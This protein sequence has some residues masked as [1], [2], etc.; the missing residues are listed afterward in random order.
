V[1]ARV[2]NQVSLELSDINVESTVETKRSRQG[3]DGLS[4]QSVEVGVGRTLN[5]EITAADVVDGLVV[6][7]DSHIGVLEKRVSGKHGVVGFNHGGGNLWGRVDGESE[8]RLAAVVNRQTLK[9]KRAETRS[10]TST[11]SVED[12]ETLKTSAVVSK[13]ADAV[14]NKVDNFLSDGV[15]TTGVVVSS[16]LLSGNQLF[17]VVQLT[18]GSGADFVNDGWFKV[19]EDSARDVLTSTSLG[20]EGVESVV[21][22]TDGLVGRHLA[23]WLDA[24]LKAVEFPARVTRLDASLADV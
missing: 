13:L 3:R 17:R 6:K 4:N 10:G 20:E 16:I 12:E 5:V 11:D 24:V 23:I 9:D 1:D 15:V 2:R 22:T 7:H 8:L 19:N 18:I 14:K 21:T